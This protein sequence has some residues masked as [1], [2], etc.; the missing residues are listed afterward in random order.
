VKQNGAERKWLIRAVET[1]EYRICIRLRRR[2]A[3]M[4]CHG[5]SDALGTLH[6]SWIVDE[7]WNEVA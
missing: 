1:A 7:D 5:E 3:I 4:S 2:R 6:S